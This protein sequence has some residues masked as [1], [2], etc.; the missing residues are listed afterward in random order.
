MSKNFLKKYKIVKK[1]SITN[2][3]K[4][5]EKLTLLKILQYNS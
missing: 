4:V 2:Y 3:F 5:F 1:N